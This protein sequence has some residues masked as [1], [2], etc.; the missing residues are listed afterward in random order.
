MSFPNNDLEHSLVRASETDDATTWLIEFGQAL[1]WVPVL[2]QDGDEGSLPVLE[3]DGQQFVP[4][5]TSEQ[6]MRERSED[7]DSFV[8]PLAGPFMANIPAGVGLVINPGG[9]GLALEPD[10]LQQLIAAGQTINREAEVSIA[11]PP[12]AIDVQPLLQA[13]VAQIEPSPLVLAAHRCWVEIDET[14][15][16]LVIALDLEPNDHDTRAQA[17]DLLRAALAT[18]EFPHPIDV[19]FHGE[20]NVFAEWMVQNTK[21]FYQG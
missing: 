15:S 12:A 10:T 7:V 13:V 1:I 6:E 19:V 4:V 11:E 21:A 17:A 5:F 9:L 8:N 14:K 20:G 18:V 2:S 3:V 16:G